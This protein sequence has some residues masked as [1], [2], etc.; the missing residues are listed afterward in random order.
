MKKINSVIFFLIAGILLA[1]SHVSFSQGDLFLAERQFELGFYNEVVEGLEFLSEKGELPIP[2]YLILGRS[3]LKINDPYRAELFLSL[4][5]S[6]DRKGEFPEF[7]F[8]LGKTAMMQGDYENARNHF[9]HFSSHDAH[10]G[11]HYARNAQIAIGI[12][13]TEP[14]VR[15]Y[16]MPWNTDGAESA[17]GMFNENLHFVSISTT[18]ET[19]NIYTQ[20]Q[21][22][23]KGTELDDPFS[24]VEKPRCELGEKYS[25]F[26]VSWCEMG[27]TAAI[28]MGRPGPS[29]YRINSN[30]NGL[31]IYLAE[32]DEN[33]DWESVL[34]F[35]HNGIGF[36]N[37]T[38]HLA[39][40]GNTLYF[41]SNRPGGFGGFD[42]YKSTRNGDQWTEPV[43]LGPEINTPGDEI[44]PFAT[45]DHL[46][47]SSD[48]HPGLGGLDVFYT[49]LSDPKN[50]FNAGRSI[51]STRDDYNFM[52]DGELRNGFL[53]SNRPG[54]RGLDDVY[55]FNAEDRLFNLSDP[56]VLVA[57]ENRNSVHSESKGDRMIIEFLKN[58]NAVFTAQPLD[59]REVSVDDVD[60]IDV[61]S[62]QIGTFKHDFDEQRFVDQLGDIGD[63][64]KV[65]Y[66][67]D[68][69]VRVG[70][71]FVREEAEVAANKIRDRG[72]P[73]A[74]IVKEHIVVSSTPPGAAKNSKGTEKK[75]SSTVSKTKYL[76]RL[77]A[78]RNTSNIDGSWM[79]GDLIK[80]ASGEFTVL[81]LGYF[82]TIEEAESARKKVAGRGFSD[83]FLMIDRN[84]ERTRYRP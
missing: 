14:L 27:K 64:Y 26:Q 36:S 41:A 75:P 71:F 61:F 67:T 34:A 81:L 6:R 15:I 62:V 20:T 50:I 42:L 69:K 66:H 8:Y 73:D 13:E 51:N 78:F 77:G 30:T 19:A 10:L 52:I 57:K 11:R 5:N 44:S 80:E 55:G 32:V 76:V 1:F 46:F 54:G 23:L 22:N 21:W 37:M 68:I 9:L 29:A 3:Y 4:G 48:W 79:D 82:D 35:D 84:G 74:F 58:S 28:V 40:N 16:N 43:N 45:G 53:V 18:K 25:A 60:Q 38:P 39:D 56:S 12:L 17:I 33:G 59:D 70:S 2:G 24:V 72:Y 63:V 31:A 47:F 7:N 83:A 65:F 49:S